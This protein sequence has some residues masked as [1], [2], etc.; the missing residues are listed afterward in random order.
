MNIDQYHSHYL[1]LLQEDY[2]RLSKPKT[3]VKLNTP[4]T[5][6]SSLIAN[7]NEAIN[8]QGPLAVDSQL[9]EDIFDALPFNGPLS[10]NSSPSEAAFAA[11][12]Y[13][14]AEQIAPPQWATEI[15]AN[16]WSQRLSNSAGSLDEAFG[17]PPRKDRKVRS[18]RCDHEKRYGLALK[19]IKLKLSD[20]PF[21][22]AVKKVS[23]TNA[24]SAKSVES[25]FTDFKK[26]QRGKGHVLRHSPESRIPTWALDLVPAP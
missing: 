7:L 14:A 3:R 12:R 2:L 8:K 9:L 19:V 11:M 22:K 24:V 15:M 17:M 6:D 1:D 5:A 23:D 26:F 4:L 25:A 16:A 21:G 20:V 18:N 13:A 10:A